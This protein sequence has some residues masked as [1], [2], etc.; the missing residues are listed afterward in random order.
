M[1]RYLI[2]ILTFLVLLTFTGMTRAAEVREPK[3]GSPER[4]VIMETMREPVS[5]RIGKRVTF[6]GSVKICGEWATFQGNVAPTD[7]VVPKSDE[8]GDL[9]LDFF[10]L[11]RLE[12]GRW[13]LLHWGFAGDIGVAEDARAKF[14]KVP[15]EL[16]PDFN[17]R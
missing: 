4:K 8:A 13:T 9:E 2:R 11:L 1:A 3:I 12:N 5:K 10:A 7:G 6:T 17:A 14:P 16:V 15:K